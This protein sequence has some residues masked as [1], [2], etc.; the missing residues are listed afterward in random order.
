MRNSS[1][2]IVKAALLVSDF[3]VI[4]GS[5][6]AAYIIRVKLDERA[7]RDPVE[8]ETFLYIFLALVPI[9][10]VIFA[11]LDLYKARVY[12]SRVEEAARLFFGAAIGVMVIVFADFLTDDPIYPARLVPV[13][14]F[15]IAYLALLLSRNFIHF[16]R[17]QL[18]RRGIGV[19]RT[20]IVATANNVN[21]VRQLVNAQPT[22]HLIIGVVG[23]RE[24][25]LFKSKR[26]K[27]YKSLE[28]ALGQINNRRIDTII[29]TGLSEN[30]DQNEK[31]VSAVQ[32]NHLEYLIYPTFATGITVQSHIE[33]LDGQPVL[34]INQTPL[35]GWWR[36]VKRI[37]DVILAILA[38]IILLPLMLI[39]G[40]II[41]ITDPG[42][43]IFK[44]RRVARFGK[45]FKVYKFRSMYQ[46]YSGVGTHTFEHR[47]QQFKEL[48][49]ED[50][51]DEFKK[52]N[53]VK[54]DPRISPFGKFIRAT[55]L[56]E[57]PQL[58]NIIKGDLSIV[59]PRP[60]APDELSM[61]E[62]PHESLFLSIRPGLTGLWQVS[63][64]ND[65]STEER[66][67]L[68]VYYIQ[69]WSLLLDIKIILKTVA[70]IIKKAGA[71]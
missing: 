51:I 10:L 53:K 27:V 4:V 58:L 69:N 45:K 41:K 66:V 11:T 36:I 34:K 54:D 30:E 71:R 8:A 60:L 9:W 20:L 6:V 55:S 18:Y 49:R 16:T 47:I 67:Q 56:D 43:A 33:L 68:D 25:K 15:A 24:N 61:F 21:L 63:G 12:Q 14:G 17:S 46:K 44:H 52:Y 40:L 3:L 13:Y 38:L 2:L 65:L 70:V 35:N 48:G 37:I 26:I 32:K 28:T 42:P 7:L 23:S 1:D 5:F 50:L 19:K 39:I 62:G 57:L 31:V 22:G 64:R 29:Q 59:G